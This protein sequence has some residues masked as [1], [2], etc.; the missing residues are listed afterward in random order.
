MSSRNT[1]LRSRIVEGFYEHRF[2]WL[3]ASIM[4]VLIA[5][6]LLELFGMNQSVLD[7]GLALCVGLAVLGFERHKPL[8]T[9]VLIWLVVAM[10]AVAGILGHQAAPRAEWTWILIGML[11]VVGTVRAA[12]RG[13]GVDGERIFA[14]LDGYLLAGMLFGACY[15][16]LS[17][18]DPA[19]FGGDA[20]LR[21]RIDAIYF[22]YATLSTVG[23]GDVA[24]VSSG[25]RSLSVVEAVGGQLYL[26]VLLAR[27]V[28]LYAP[29]TRKK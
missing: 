5:D 2:G 13:S 4:L 18:Q 26:A 19:T 23:Y 1:G 10:A 22:S 12:L 9:R 7:R 21:T 11:V 25:A 27:L 28:S 8:A 24:P 15:W 17:Q 14:A 16:Q 6:P 3:F 29:G 20:G